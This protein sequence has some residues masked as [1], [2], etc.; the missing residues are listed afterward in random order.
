MP[1]SAV[2]VLPL[3]GLALALRLTLAVALPNDEPDD[4]RMYARLAHNLL[5]HGIYSVDEK[6]PYSATYDRVPGYPLFLAVVYKLF[7]DGNNLAVRVVQ[8]L[9]DALTCVG[10]GLVAALWSPR[11][12]DDARRR[13]AGLWALGLAAVC[14]FVAIYVTTILT[15][16][17][18]MALGMAVLIAA[19]CAFAAADAERVER[20]DSRP[21]LALWALTGLA[22]G[23]MTLVRPESGLY[24]AAV[25]ITLACTS[26]PVGRWRDWA[27]HTIRAGLALAVGFAAVLTPWAARN[28][29]QFGVFEPLNPRSVSMPGEFVAE[30]YAAWMRSWIDHPRYVGPLLFNLD[31]QPISVDDVPARAFDSAEE[32]AEVADLFRRYSSPAPD[33]EAD[34]SGHVPP[35]GMTPDIDARFGAIARARAS[36]AKLRQ[37][38][39]LPVERAV[40]LWFDP[41]AD[42]YPFAGFLFPLS[43]LDPDQ[44]Q[45]FWLPLFL[46]LTMAWTIAGAAGVRALWR[47]SGSRRWLLLVAM[48]VLPRLALLASMENP[49]PRYTVEFFPLLTVLAG[50]ALAGRGSAAARSFETTERADLVV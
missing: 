37:Y 46:T 34:E 33:A 6:P 19:T 15:E 30:G 2:I 39:V 25:G 3:L 20:G 32:R 36:R 9:I 44:Q 38:I 17:L 27:R 14:S 13:R 42:Y 7:G 8:A 45:Q 5:E 16:T 43:D 41:H 29:A 50:C 49:E 11:E 26:A 4:G 10:A 12:W 47:G 1:R 35:S 24:V 31:R 18:A 22:G 40:M 48:V 21:A 23:A 28:A